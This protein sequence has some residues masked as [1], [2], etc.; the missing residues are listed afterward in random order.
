MNPTAEDLS[1]FWEEE[2]ESTTYSSE[3]E[4]EEPAKNVVTG[5]EF[6]KLAKKTLKLGAESLDCSPPKDNKYAATLKNW[7]KVHFG[8]PQYPDVLINQDQEQKESQ[9]NSQ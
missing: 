5:K 8:S 4:E 6:A 3:E 2:Q 9:E 1:D 7:K